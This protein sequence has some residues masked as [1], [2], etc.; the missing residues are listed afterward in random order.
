MKP[1]V[2]YNTAMPQA[3]DRR[4]A[5]ILAQLASASTW[6]LTAA[7]A[8]VDF[9]GFRGLNVGTPVNETDAAR[10]YDI[11]YRTRNL[12]AGTTYTITQ[13][14]HGKV[15][16]FSSNSPVTITVPVDATTGWTANG[17]C[18]PFNSGTGGLT[19][20][21]DGTSVIR[22]VGGGPATMTR[23]YSTA[24]LQR[25]TTSNYV[26]SGETDQKIKAADVHA[27]ALIALSQLNTQA[28]NTV[29]ANATG[30]GAV[31]TALTMGASTVLARLAAGNVVAATPAQ[32]VTLLGLNQPLYARA[33]RQAASGD[34][35]LNSTTWANLGDATSGGAG[36]STAM[37]DLTLAAVSGQWIEVGFLGFWSSEAVTAYMDA[38]TLV[39]SSIV[40][41]VTTGNATDNTLTPGGWEGVASRADQLSGS[42]IYQLVSGDV[43]GGNVVLRPIFRTG[44]SANKT[45]KGTAIAPFIFWAKALP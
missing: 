22:V 15:L 29:V 43:S 32:I 9:G 38:G 6:Y 12:I 21:D 39:S 27:S 2:P 42:V 37:Y 36:M 11:F 17:W 31:P 25:N 26:L 14:D 19:F 1:A 41:S 34:M 13:A 3:A 16:Q 7:G 23:Q 10:A 8:T 45:L 35:T 44:S 40:H 24:L 30:S 18:I 28:A 33:I 20:V 4:R 5:M